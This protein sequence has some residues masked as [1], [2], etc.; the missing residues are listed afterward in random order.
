[1]YQ[2]CLFLR[3]ENNVQLDRK[4]PI[5][6]REKSARE[7]ISASIESEF[8]ILKLDGEEV[9][10]NK[11]MV[12]SDLLQEFPALGA[13]VKDEFGIQPSTQAP[14]S[15]KAMKDLELVDYEPAADSGHFRFY[16]RGTIIFELLRLWAEEIALNRLGAHQII[17]PII[18]GWKHDDIRSQAE[19]FHEHHYRVYPPG[20]EGDEQEKFILRF[21]GDFGLFRMMRD[22]QLTYRHLPVR[23]YEFSPSFRYENSGSLSGLRRVRA[24]YMPDIHSFCVDLEQGFQEYKKLYQHY[25]DLTNGF[26]VEYAVAFR[27]VKSFYEKH[28][29]E[30]LEMIRYSGQPAYIELLSDMKHYWVMKHEINTIDNNQGVCQV[31]TVQLDI[32]DASLYGINYTDSNGDKKGCT[33][34]H[35]SIGSP[36]RWIYSILEHALKQEVPSLPLWLAPIQVRVLPI[37]DDKHLDFCRDLAIKLKENQIRCDVDDRPNPLNWR[38]RRSEIEW[39]PFSVICGDKEMKSGQ[40]SIRI[41]GQGQ[42]IMS[43]DDLIH[44]IKK[45]VEGMPYMPL[46]DL[47]LTERPVLRSRG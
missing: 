26:S 30:L 37:S 16:P 17:T 47:L 7:K 4:E 21:A 39:V 31:S 14:P 43:L 33:I 27:I 8:L 11:Q 28:K 10:V 20:G 1:V 32:K 19:S 6:A 22:A 23:M 40:L 35:S 45:Q 36:E 15:I 24:F 41:R 29:D 25:T 12:N 44:K 18:Y 13:L 2:K 9:P 34:V 38:I 5:M 46:P 42:Q 3:I